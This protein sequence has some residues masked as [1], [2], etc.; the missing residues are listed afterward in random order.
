M[1]STSMTRPQTY[2]LSSRHS[3]SVMVSIKF[4]RENQ[5]QCS[6]TCSCRHDLMAYGP[7]PTHAWMH[8]D[9]NSATDS[10]QLTLTSSRARLLLRRLLHILRWPH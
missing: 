7:A 9:R 3:S 5:R 10:R 8:L 4:T 6:A 1:D 2:H